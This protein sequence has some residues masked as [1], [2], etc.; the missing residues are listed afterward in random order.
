MKKILI[1]NTALILLFTLLVS[2][3]DTLIGDEGKLDET[4]Y[5]NYTTKTYLTLPFKEQWTVVNGGRVHKDGAHHFLS[6]SERYAFDAYI[7]KKGK[8]FSG[9]GKKNE[10]YYCFGVPLFAPSDGKVVHVVNNIKD[11][12]PG[13]LNSEQA[14]GNHVIIDHLNGEFSYIAHFKKNSIVVKVG[15][16]LTKGQVIGRTGNSG[17]STEPHLHYHLQNQSDENDA[18]SLPAQFKNYFADDKFIERGEPV[19]DQIIKSLD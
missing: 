19:K 1:K 5:L 17:N 15:D 18:I 4:L 14:G 8:S 3:T 10:D 6:R 13:Q 9:N 7:E 16:N 2:C 12:E 11:N